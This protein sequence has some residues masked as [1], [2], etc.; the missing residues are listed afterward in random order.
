VA[1]NR[2][3]ETHG[4]S[5][6][7][8]GASTPLSLQERDEH[9]TALLADKGGV[10]SVSA[11]LQP[12]LVDY[13]QAVRLRD[14]A[15]SHIAQIGPLTKAGR[16]RAATDLYLQASAR[17]Q[18]LAAQVGLGRAPAKVPSLQEY[19]SARLRNEQAASQD[20]NLDAGGDDGASDDST[21]PRAADGDDDQRDDL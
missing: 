12:Q 8:R 13:A 6:L 20:D 1:G 17:A 7:Q 14:L 11:V 10:D 15:W 18:A 9:V 19:L 4:L 5:H 16:R 2:F 3:A 21:A